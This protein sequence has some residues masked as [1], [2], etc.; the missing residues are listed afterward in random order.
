MNLN[1]SMNRMLWNRV[2][3]R[4]KEPEDNTTKRKELYRVIK[5]SETCQKIKM[6]DRRKQG[7]TQR[8]WKANQKQTRQ[9]Q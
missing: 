4:D 3:E 9:I 6:K 5:K 2:E 8:K 7:T 1:Q